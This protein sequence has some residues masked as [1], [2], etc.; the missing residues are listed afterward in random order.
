MGRDISLKIEIVKQPDGGGVLR[1][2]RE[3]GSI[4]WQTQAKHAQHFALHDLT[5]Y[6]VET[7]LASKSGFFGL[8]AQGW[9]IEDTTGKGSRGPLPEEAVAIEKVVG[10]FDTERASGARWTLDQFQEYSPRA[11]TRDQVDQ[12]RK[13][14]G[15]VFA[16]WSGTDPGQSLELTFGD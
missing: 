7:A 2:T 9:N 8:I 13:L 6:S 3:D 10:I 16:R 11:L 12:I 15:E 5:H 4:T 1:C 14:R